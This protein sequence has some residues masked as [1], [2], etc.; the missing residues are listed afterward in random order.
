M[1]EEANEFKIIYSEDE[2]GNRVVTGYSDVFEKMIKDSVLS[3]RNNNNQYTYTYL[4]EDRIGNTE[5]TDDEYDKLAKNAQT[6]LASVLRINQLT[7]YFINKD[8]IIGLVYNAIENNVNGEIRLSFDGIDITKIKE[9]EIKK[10]EQTKT[11]LNK[12]N[13][14]INI[15]KFIKSVIPNSY[16]EGNYIV[17][18][19]GD[20]LQNYSILRIP[21]GVGLISDY[22]IDGNPVIY[23]DINKLVSSLQKTVITSKKT[24]KA[25]T[26]KVEEELQKIFP[27]EVYKGYKDKEQFVQLD[28]RRTGVVRIGNMEKKYGVTPIFRTFRAA[29]MLDV[30]KDADKVNTKA[31]AKKI[32]F[33][34]LNID[35][36]GENKKEPSFDL[37]AFAHNQLMAAWNNPVVIYTGAP[38][39]EDLKYVEPSVETD[40][41]KQVQLYRNEIMTTLGIGYLNNENSQTFTVANIT[42]A[43]LMKNINKIA[44]Q[45]EDIIER[46]YGLFI[47]QEGLDE[48]YIPT[49]EI[50]DSELM[51][52]E[53]KIQLVDTLYNKLNL[54]LQTSLEILGYSYTEELQRR[55]KE[56]NN[57]THE[58]MF[59]RAN[60][61]NSSGDK[62]EDNKG[63]RPIDNND[64]DKQLEDQN[65]R[66]AE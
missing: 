56:N 22:E 28:H 26:L 60:A 44:E 43:E 33:Q 6:D 53:M 37:M 51:S 14:K 61:Y 2:D 30:Y 25:I 55:L 20:S 24:K 50:I 11:R 52:Q 39:V 34:K 10:L 29:G 36:M 54:S 13:K 64:P 1:N 23:I 65:R 47:E 45:V 40:N 62:S 59:P 12:L 41:T 57:G 5:L 27:P 46:W 9:N 17:Y 58:I 7:R 49:P 3:Y 38:F 19:K 35:I 66:Q 48:E 18:L 4:K 15:K 63:G 42:I 8:E 21:L 32:I 31:K 16:A